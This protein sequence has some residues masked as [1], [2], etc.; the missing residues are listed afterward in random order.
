M[1][2]RFRNSGSKG[3]Q[4]AERLLEI[5]LHA[6]DDGI[7]ITDTKQTVV[8]ANQAFCSF[9]GRERREVTGTTMPIWLEQID[10]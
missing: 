4:Q 10:S 7:V 6:S 9:F 3:T 2:R 1:G 8:M 5:L